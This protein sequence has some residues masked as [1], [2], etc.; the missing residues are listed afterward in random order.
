MVYSCIINYLLLNGLSRYFPQLCQL[1]SYWYKIL[2]SASIQHIFFSSRETS[3]CTVYFKLIHS[4]IDGKR[5]SQLLG[6]QI[7]VPCSHYHHHV[8]S[9]HSCFRGSVTCGAP[10]MENSFQVAKFEVQ[11]LQVIFVCTKKWPG[12]IWVACIGLR[13]RSEW[14]LRCAGAFL[15][16]FWTFYNT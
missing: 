7:T 12:V 15:E 11:R 5:I 2:C 8:Y 9:A 1:P 3:S 16:S 10:L 14:S 4:N 13:K 6:F